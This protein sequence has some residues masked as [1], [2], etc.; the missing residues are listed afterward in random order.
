MLIDKMNLR[1]GDEMRVLRLRQQSFVL[2]SEGLHPWVLFKEG[3]WLS[4]TLMARCSAF[5]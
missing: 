3:A 1:N 4:A 2:P 5:D